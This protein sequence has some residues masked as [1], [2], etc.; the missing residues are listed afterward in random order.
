MAKSRRP[1]PD[2]SM[3]PLVAQREEAEN[4]PGEPTSVLVGYLGEDEGDSVRLY[5]DSNL[6]V[7]YRVP[8]ADIVSTQRGEE[9]D[10]PT[11]D[12]VEVNAGAKVDI[13]MPAEASFLKGPIA[14]RLQGMSAAAGP[15]GVADP[16][17]LLTLILGCG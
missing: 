13:V 16:T 1:K 7:Y 14:D 5:T 3:H 10:H 2:L 9:G 15:K 12:R 4:A 6:R 11:P 8:K 17:V